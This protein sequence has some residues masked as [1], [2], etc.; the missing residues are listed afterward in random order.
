MLPGKIL[1]AL[2]R[3][4]DMELA[5]SFLKRIGER[6][7]L[8]FAMLEFRDIADDLV[9]EFDNPKSD[10]R[11]VEGLSGFEYEFSRIPYSVDRMPASIFLEEAARKQCDGII[12]VSSFTNGNALFHT[13]LASTLAVESSIPV[14]VVQ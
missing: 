4:E 5:V 1:V 14:M 3:N 6:P 10:N 11:P 2:R 9:A 7:R 8:V 13:D 12:V